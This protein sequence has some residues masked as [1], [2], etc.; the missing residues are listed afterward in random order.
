M[1]PLEFVGP[2]I[3]EDDEDP[4]EDTLTTTMPTRAYSV[5]LQRIYITKYKIYQEPTESSPNLGDKINDSLETKTSEEGPLTPDSLLSVAPDSLDPPSPGSDPS[6]NEP[7]SDNSSAEDEDPE[8]VINRAKQELLAGYVLR[9]PIY[10]PP[11]ARSNQ[12]LTS[13]IRARG[14]FAA[15]QRAWKK[16]RG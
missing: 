16:D 12:N 4:E 1:S 11:T 9:P 2:H 7:E 14:R 10:R 6:D 8:L 5:R 3:H 15:T 13:R